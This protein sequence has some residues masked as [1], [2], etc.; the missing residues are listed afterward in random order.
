[1]CFLNLNNY[2]ISWKELFLYFFYTFFQPFFIF[3]LIFHQLYPLAAEFLLQHPSLEGDTPPAKKRRS[4]SDFGVI[5]RYLLDEVFFYQF[6]YML[7]HIMFFIVVFGVFLS[8]FV[9]SF[10]FFCL[11]EIMNECLAF[12][13]LVKPWLGW[14]V[15]FLPSECLSIQE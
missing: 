8:L 13:E 12:S 14:C 1:M 9:F 7:I 11:S 10:F 15:V 3:P 6:N 5:Q 4:V 2:L